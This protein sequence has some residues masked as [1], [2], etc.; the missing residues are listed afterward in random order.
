MLE[1]NGTTVTAGLTLTAG[2][3][4][5][6]PA[7]WWAEAVVDYIGHSNVY[8]GAFTFYCL[9]YTGMCASEIEEGYKSLM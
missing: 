2:A 9:R 6:I 5:A 3:V 4:P 1:L 8:I 7:L